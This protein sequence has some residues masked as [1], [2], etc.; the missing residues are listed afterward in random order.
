MAIQKLTKMRVRNKTS[1]MMSDLC[2]STALAIGESER[3]NMKM[4]L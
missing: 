3:M 1:D 2:W 4:H